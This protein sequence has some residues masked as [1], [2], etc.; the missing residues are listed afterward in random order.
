MHDTGDIMLSSKLQ[1]FLNE[2]ALE[3][4]VLFSAG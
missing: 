3:L 2:I 4:K 1:A